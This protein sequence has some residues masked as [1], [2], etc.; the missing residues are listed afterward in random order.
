M[1]KKTDLF[2]PDR[3]VNGRF[4]TRPVLDLLRSLEGAQVEVCVRPRQTYASN[5]QHRYYRGV[6]IRLLAMCMRDHGTQSPGGGPITDEEVHQMMAGR[7]LKET[8]LV[9]PETGECMDVVI[10]T[11]KATSARMTQYI[12][13]VRAWA[14]KVFDLDIPDPREAGDVR[15]A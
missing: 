12:E 11:A 7:F 3:V 4:V 9:D 14:L 10:S 2:Y 5:N 13:D 1:A 15:V 6:V 8:V